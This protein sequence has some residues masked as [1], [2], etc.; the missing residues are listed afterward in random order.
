MQSISLLGDLS[1]VTR[2]PSER[3][4]MNGDEEVWQHRLTYLAVSSLVRWHP[5][6]VAGNG[7]FVSAGVSAGW[8]FTYTVD[9]FE[10][11]GRVQERTE[12]F[13]EAIGSRTVSIGAVGGLGIV[14]PLESNRVTLEA[15]YT[16][17][18]SDAYGTPDFDILRDDLYHT[19][20]FATILGISF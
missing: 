11:E 7:L 1:I 10:S 12:Y 19:A 15:R 14:L 9:G 5:F 2:A 18:L 3:E 17:G 8:R 16:L 6:S 20:D 4:T 13:D